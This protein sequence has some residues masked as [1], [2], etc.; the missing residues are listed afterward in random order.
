MRFIDLAIRWFTYLIAV[1]AAVD[2]LEIDILSTFMKSVVQYIPSFIAG[3]S[4]L[5]I[6]LVVV[7]FV[8]DAFWTVGREAKIEFVGLI[9]GI[10]KL[11]MYLIVIVIALTMIGI[12]VSIIYTFVNAL[13]LGAAIGI[14]V[15]L[16]IAFGWGLRMS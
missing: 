2:I 6:G 4:I 16:G 13:T 7:D 12:D 14:C 1:L 8:G 9:A 10:S 3:V 5:F 11:V 15:G